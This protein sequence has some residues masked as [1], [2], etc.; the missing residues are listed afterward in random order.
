MVG[1]L[2]GQLGLYSGT[3]Q[4]I[5]ELMDN[6]LDEENSSSTAD[7]STSF[8]PL[9]QQ[10]KVDKLVFRY[11]GMETNVLDKI[12]LNFGKGTYVV[13]TGGSGSGKSTIL[14]ILYRFRKPND[15]SVEWDGTSK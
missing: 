13:L 5:Q 3:L 14:N 12:N 15:G 1:N 9:S 6:S 4:A 8:S 7:K 2:K 10:M 11:D